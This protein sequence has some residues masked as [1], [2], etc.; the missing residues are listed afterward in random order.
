MVLM[1]PASSQGVVRHF[2]GVQEA[3][4]HLILSVVAHKHSPTD[5]GTQIFD[6]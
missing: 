5:Q 6:I 4:E 3:L 2:Q 1:N